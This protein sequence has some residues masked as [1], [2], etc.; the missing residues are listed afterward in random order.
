MP[1]SLQSLLIWLQILHFRLIQQK[2]GK[3]SCVASLWLVCLASVCKTA[4]HV[5][6]LFTKALDWLTNTLYFQ[7]PSRQFTGHTPGWFSFSQIPEDTL[8]SDFFNWIYPTAGHEASRHEPFPSPSSL[9]DRIAIKRLCPARSACP[10]PWCRHLTCP[11]GARSGRVGA[12]ATQGGACRSSGARPNR[13]CSR[14][15]ACCSCSYATSGA[16][17]TLNVPPVGCTPTALAFKQLSMK[18]VPHRNM[19]LWSKTFILR[20]FVLMWVS[21]F[22]QT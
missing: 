6:A 22:I 2:T 1:C 14:A 21:V 10:V 9:W 16:A 3:H 8:L 12:R 18:I 15:A 20:T 13:P 19:T 11:W 7:P 5:P 17:L 4:A